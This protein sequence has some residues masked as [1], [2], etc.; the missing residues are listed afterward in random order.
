M[1]SRNRPI[2]RGV[3]C[4]ARVGLILIACG[5]GCEALLATRAAGAELQIVP[6]VSITERYDS[7]VFFAPESFA[8]GQTLW[9]FSTVTTPQIQVQNTG[10]LVSG[11]LRAGVSGSVY[12]NN[13]ELNFV[14]TNAG[15][16]L[17]L[18]GW[19]GR[20]VKGATLQVSDSFNFTPE[21]PA[22]LSPRAADEPER[23][24]VQGIQAFRANTVSNAASVSGSLPVSQTVKAQAS[25]SH[26]LI[27]FGRNFVSGSGASLLDS[28]TQRATTGVS[29]S[30]SER[31]AMDFNYSFSATE[32]GGG[33]RAQFTTHSGMAG[34]QRSISPRLSA[35]VSAGGT[36]IDTTDRLV[37][38]E[39]ARLSWKYSPRT[40]MS[41]GYSRQ[42]APSFFLVD[43]VLVSQTVNGSIVHQISQRLSVTG[44]VNY[45]LSES[46]PRDD[47]RFE[48]FGTSINWQY[49]VTKSMSASLS[50]SFNRFETKSGQSQFEFDRHIVT[51]GVQAVFN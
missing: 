33:Q 7:N 27:R 14:S 19:V 44:A 6:S 8:P 9:D 29:V 17:T 10:R 48:S 4:A 28:T 39:N 42:V 38:V 49:Q 45:A 26:S 23:L 12:V 36:Y 2:S 1:W 21:P 22:F 16:N 11:S 34:Y 50:Y 25:Y 18:D 40:S 24:F 5:V 30:L 46:T 37:H 31:D 15:V 51:L 41:A 20:A 35:S 43:T 3:R 32:F 13:P 47:A